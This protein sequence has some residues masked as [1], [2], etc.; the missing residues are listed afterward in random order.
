[1]KRKYIAIFALLYL[2]FF[3]YVIHAQEA[4]LGFDTIRFEK[5]SKSIGKYSFSGELINGICIQNMD[6]LPASKFY[7]SFNGKSGWSAFTNSNGTDNWIR[8]DL[9]FTHSVFSD[10]MRYGWDCQYYCPGAWIKETKWIKNDDGSI[11][12]ETSIERILCKKKGVFCY[13]DDMGKTLGHF[14]FIQDPKKNENL[15]KCLVNL[16]S[17]K[18]NSGERLN[19]FAVYG[20]FTGK[21][22]LIFYHANSGRFYLFVE[23]E[24]RGIYSPDKPQ[25]F[26]RKNKLISP[27]LIVNKN[28][29]TDDRLIVMHLAF[30]CQWLKE[31][32][33]QTGFT[34]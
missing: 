3:G 17:D 31:T 16:Y 25:L 10:E 34:D 2:I 30:V 20:E 12:L 28:Q 4:L 8:E 13:L 18:L 22:S 27:Q 24:L 26:T 21:E 14:S 32:L 23:N 6:L 19:E 1:M 29:N 7:H 9:S 15:N 33:N 11:S 5:T